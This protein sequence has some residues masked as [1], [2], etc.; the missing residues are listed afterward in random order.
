MVF[1]HGT[2]KKEPNPQVSIPIVCER[3]SGMPQVAHPERPSASTP[4]S[5]SLLPSLHDESYL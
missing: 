4:N 3:W 1:L 2:F 5:T